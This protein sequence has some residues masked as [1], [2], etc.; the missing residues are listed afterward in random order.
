MAGA[1]VK[2][3]ITKGIVWNM[4]TVLGKR[5]SPV[6]NGHTWQEQLVDLSKRKRERSRFLALIDRADI[7][8]WFDAIKEIHVLFIQ[9]PPATKREDLE[10]LAAFITKVHKSVR[11]PV[12]ALND[13][14]Q[15]FSIAL[16]SEKP[17]NDYQVRKKIREKKLK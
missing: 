12:I 6:T 11:L 3:N 10:F 14:P 2:F 1:T 4:W 8:Y 16:T 9:M 17:Q 7:D 5:T 15:N 13:V